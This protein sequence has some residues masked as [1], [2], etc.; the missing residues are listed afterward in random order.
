MNRLA[1]AVLILGLLVAIGWAAREKSSDAPAGGEVGAGWAAA[2][3]AQL[4]RVLNLPAAVELKFKEVGE[5]PAPGYHLVVFDLVTGDRREPLQL[6]VSRDGRRLLYDRVYDLENPFQAL[7]EQIRLDNVPGRGPADA[8]VTI[9]EYSDFTCSYCRRFY[10][11]LLGPL[12]ERYGSKVRVVYKNFPLTGLRA[13]SEDAAIAGACAFRQGNQR[14]WALHDR[15]FQETFRLREGRPLLRELA[16][17]VGLDVP[18]FT[19][20]LDQR[21]G[22]VDV[23]RD[24]TEG[25]RLGVDGTPTFFVNGRPI[26]GLVPTELFFQIVDEELAAAQSR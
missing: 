2:H 19:A 8:P 26:P 14:F 13:W 15:L 23:A 12:F 4:R 11:T 20:C 10:E 17:E 16:G 24:V 18:A 3:N 9:V 6:Y 7:R 21:D 25:E 22:L 5:S 1:S